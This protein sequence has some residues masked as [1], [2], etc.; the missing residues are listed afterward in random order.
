M[1]RT[2]SIWSVCLLLPVK[3]NHS[4]PVS[5]QATLYSTPHM[6]GSAA[7]IAATTRADCCRVGNGVKL[8]VL[9]LV[10]LGRHLEIL[11]HLKTPFISKLEPVVPVYAA[12]VGPTN[13]DCPFRIGQIHRLIVSINVDHDP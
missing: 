13:K 6:E 10:S 7:P 9:A 3:L 12:N 1:P 8:A 5:Y 2:V 11:T 4:F